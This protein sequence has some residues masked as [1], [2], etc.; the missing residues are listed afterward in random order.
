MRPSTRP[1]EDY[2]FGELKETVKVY[3][4]AFQVR[5][6]VVVNRAAAK[7]AGGSLTIA[8]SV[9]YQACDDKVCFPPASAPVSIMLPI[10]PD[11]SGPPAGT[12]PLSCACRQRATATGR[13]VRADSYSATIVATFPRES[14]SVTRGSRTPAAASARSSSSPM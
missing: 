3:S 2:V 4:R 12:R 14:A 9:R 6:Q 5:Q 8:G 11:A 13:P 10:A 7:T 1:G